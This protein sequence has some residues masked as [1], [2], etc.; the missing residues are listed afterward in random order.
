MK[1]ASYFMDILHILPDRLDTPE[2]IVPYIDFEKHSRTKN[3]YILLLYTLPSYMIGL[4]NLHLI[5]QRSDMV[6]NYSSNVLRI[7]LYHTQ[8]NFAHF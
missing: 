2:L 6:S 5:L 8:Y 7:H 4:Y 3:I 1:K